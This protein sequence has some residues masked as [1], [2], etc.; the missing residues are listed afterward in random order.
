MKKLIVVLIILNSMSM[1][2]KKRSNDFLISNTIPKRLTAQEI[3][4]RLEIS[5]DIYV[6]DKTGKILIHKPYEHTLWRFMGESNFERTWSFS[7]NDIK[8]LKRINL[9]HNWNI[10]D[11]GVIKLKL[12]QYK[13]FIR[14]NKKERRYIPKGLIKEEEFIVN[15]FSQITW[16]AYSDNKR[17]V[18]VRF[19]PSLQE[20]NGPQQLAELPIAGTNMVVFDNK[21][22]LWANNFSSNSKYMGFITYK[23]AI[24]VSYYPF[25]GAKEMGYAKD[26]KIT[27]T[28]KSGTQVKI[29]SLTPFLPTGMQAKIYAKY[30][31]DVKTTRINSYQVFGSSKEKK[32]LEGL[33]KN[34]R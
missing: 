20:G 29:K 30:L 10:G 13:T 27:I 4:N 1:W 16:V 12:G 19:T 18:V 33:K 25:S 31:P 8:D 9:L 32:I 14:E 6:T 11:D 7:L 5:G 15:N 22:N 28:L 34:V 2:A 26:N 3:R 24:A 17:R 21:G 23:G